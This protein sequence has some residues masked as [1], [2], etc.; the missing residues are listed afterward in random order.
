MSPKHV[1]AAIAAAACIGAANAQTGPT[2]ADWATI[3]RF[4]SLV[5][6]FMQAAC[7][8][9]STTSQPCDPNAAQK[10]FDDIASGRNPDANA[11]MLDIF[12]GVPPAER[13]KMLAIG[14]SMAAMS[15]KQVAAE[16]PFPALPGESAAIQA[17]KDLTAIGLSYHD[18][19]QFLDAVK[20]KDVIAVQLFLTGRGVDPNARD[21]FGN[22]AL[23]L[24]RRGGD[25]EI[26]ALLSAAAPR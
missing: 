16:A 10:A 5:Q 8:P 13:E 19:N 25:P 6:M 14:R 17:R 7:P 9:A 15:R 3:G 24:A 21:A 11:L 20:R 1:L 2:A 23:D 18:R 22:T 26:I 4:L 12:A